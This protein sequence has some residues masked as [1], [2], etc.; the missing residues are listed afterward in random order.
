MRTIAISPLVEVR[1]PDDW[2]AYKI[3]ALEDRERYQP[4]QSVQSVT[5]PLSLLYDQRGLVSDC[6]GTLSCRR[7]IKGADKL[8]RAFR[9][10]LDCKKIIVA[11]NGESEDMKRYRTNLADALGEDLPKVI[12]SF[13]FAGDKQQLAAKNNIPFVL[14]DNLSASNAKVFTIDYDDHSRE[15]HIWTIG[16][17][18]LSN[19][20]D[21]SYTPKVINEIVLA[22]FM[23][24]G[25]L[26]RL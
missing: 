14:E 21:H 22:V 7:L 6:G 2:A 23:V 15:K 10:R 17:P 9:E 26:E 12:D 3:K 8:L 11:T 13:E 18:S 4:S 25:E 5:K 16:V 19:I 24:C 20:P 1:L